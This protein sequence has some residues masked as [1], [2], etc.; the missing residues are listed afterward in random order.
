MLQRCTSEMKACIDK[1]I[2]NGTTT[3]G[4]VS[5]YLLQK[6]YCRGLI[7]IE[8]PIN[9]DTKVAGNMYIARGSMK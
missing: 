1:M 5:Y 9:A 4:T 2:D 8:V 7:Y 3:A 6:L